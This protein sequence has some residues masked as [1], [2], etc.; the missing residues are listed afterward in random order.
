MKQS[1]KVAVD[2]QKRSLN[3]YCLPP[4]IFTEM[5]L[6]RDYDSSPFNIRLPSDKTVASSGA[7]AIL[8][9][10]SASL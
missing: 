4:R 5:R 8:I 10:S 1:E 3:S 7:S 2:S 6:F 9:P